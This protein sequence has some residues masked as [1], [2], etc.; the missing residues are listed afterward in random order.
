MSIEHNNVATEEKAAI[1]QLLEKSRRTDIPA[2]L[3]A[4]EKVKQ[5]LRTDPSVA[6]LLSRLDSML[7]KAEEKAMVNEE[8]IPEFF[9]NVGQVLRYLQEEAGRAIGQSKLYADIKKG[10]L[11]KDNKSFR[12]ID[13]DRYAATLPLATTPDGRVAEAEERQRRKDEAEIRIKEAQAEREEKK[14]LILS[15]QYID[16][17]Q[18]YQEFAARAV[19]LNMGIKTVV[20]E[21]ALDLILAVEGKQQKSDLLVRLFEEVI[22]N[23]CNE[24]SRELTF[25]VH[26]NATTDETNQNDVDD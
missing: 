2:L 13:V 20:Q 21:K 18:V 24:Y 8:G 16:R 22:D 25:E 1:E 7:E 26:L 3:H 9:K 19:A 15:G 17:E 23:A 10:L 5:M 14:N 4:R 12:K 11:R 6:P